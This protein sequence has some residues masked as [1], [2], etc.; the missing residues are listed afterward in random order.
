MLV[1]VLV[2]DDYAPFREFVSSALRN[3]RNLQTVAEASDGLEAIRKAE[4]FRPEL[5]LLDIGMPEL[6]GME[7]APRI[8][9]LLPNSKILFVSQ[10]SSPDIVQE[11]FASGASGYVVKA[12]AA[13]DLLAAVEAVLQG[14]HFVGARF[15]GLD[16]ILSHTSI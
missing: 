6:S 16:L 4:K 7:V 11:A 13:Q 9:S 2:V 3:K 10:E 15:A 5:I 14:K 12:D 8:R 1:K